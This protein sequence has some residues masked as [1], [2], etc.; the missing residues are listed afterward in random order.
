[1]FSEKMLAA[2]SHIGIFL[3]FVDKLYNKLVSKAKKP[4]PDGITDL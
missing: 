1:M 3:V 4:D 2:L